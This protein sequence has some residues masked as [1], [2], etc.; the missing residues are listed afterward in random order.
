M[1]SKGNKRWKEWKRRLKQK[2]PEKIKELRRAWEKTRRAKRSGRIKCGPCAICGETKG[3]QAH[4]RDYAT[5][6]N[7]EWLCHK[8][9]RQAHGFDE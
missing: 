7:I 4:H 1:A 5:S 2:N 9:H 6:L 8:H 3:V